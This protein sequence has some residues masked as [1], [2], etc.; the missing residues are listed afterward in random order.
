M[1]CRRHGQSRPRVV[2]GATWEPSSNP[3]LMMSG[4]SFF[5]RDAQATD[6]RERHS[7]ALRACVN[8]RQALLRNDSRPSMMELASKRFPKYLEIASGSLS[9]FSALPETNTWP[10]QMM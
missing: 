10:S 4:P 7:L 3:E 2:I 5:K 6:Q 9:T 1:N 8:Q